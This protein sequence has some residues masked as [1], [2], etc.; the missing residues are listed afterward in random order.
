MNS[1][2]NLNPTQQDTAPATDSSENLDPK[3]QDD[4]K[5]AEASVKRNREEKPKGKKKKP[6]P[7]KKKWRDGVEQRM[8][9]LEDAIAAQEKAFLKSNDIG[10]VEEDEKGEVEKSN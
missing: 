7:S 2:A 1:S 6:C 9:A 5:K 4:G 10:P 8:K 3:E